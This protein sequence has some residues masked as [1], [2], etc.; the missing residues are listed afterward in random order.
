MNKTDIQNWLTEHEIPFSSSASLIQLRKL[1]N[2]KR[3]ELDLNDE[4][5]DDN[6][7]DAEN[8]PLNPQQ[9]EINLDAEIRILEK[10]QRIQQLQRELTI[11][12]VVSCPNFEDVQHLMN[13]F[14]ETYD[15]YKW[16]K[17]FERVCDS[18]SADDVFRLR[19]VRRLMKMNSA[20][21]LFLRVDNSTNFSNFRQNFLSNFGRKH[22]ISEV[23][24]ELRKTTYCSSKLSIIGYILKMQELA[25][26]ANMDE[27]EVIQFI[28][29]G[30]EDDSVDIAVLY[31]ANDL[32]QLKEL[33][34]RYG[35]LRS[36][37]NFKNQKRNPSSSF[38]LNKNDDI[39]KQ[40]CF[41]CSQIGHF[42]S[43]C[44]NPKREKGSCFRCG[45]KEHILNNC[46]K[47]S[48]PQVA[49]VDQFEKNNISFKTS[50]SHDEHFQEINDIR[51]YTKDIE[52]VQ[53]DL[54]SIQKENQTLQHELNL[55]K[56]QIFESE[57]TA[58]EATNNL[59]NQQKLLERIKQLEQKEIELQDETHELR[60]Q[61]ELLEFRILELEE[62]ND[63][64]S[65][66]SN[67]TPSSK[68][69]WNNVGG[70]ES[71][72]AIIFTDRS[73]S[74]VTSPHSHHH[75]DDRIN[76]ISPCDL[77]LLDHMTNEDLRR[78]LSQIL[79][80]PNIDEEDKICLQQVLAFVQNLEAMSH[81][82]DSLPSSEESSSLE[83]IKSR[84]SDYSSSS[85]SSD[86]SPTLQLQKPKSTPTSQGRIVATV[87]PYSSAVSTPNDSPQRK[88]RAW[89]TTSLTESG[90]FE[91]D[92][93]ETSVYPQTEP[94][95]FSNSTETTE[96]QK[97]NRIREQF[98]ECAKKSAYAK[99]PVT[100][101][102]SLS[103]NFSDQKRIQYY[104]E[105]LE[106]LEGKLLL[107]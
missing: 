5:N 76:V 45:S 92:L 89:H 50:N 70:K 48:N 101:S 31:P 64:W 26:Q 30:F 81:G 25:G 37:R 69:V 41:N 67:T 96:A 100:S 79:K 17:D 78:R 87:L 83:Y 11:N 73:D 60:E 47:K 94:E 104:K 10:R 9:E 105:R 18:L 61:N 95:D 44:P 63:K 29:A 91:G 103:P 39:K 80:K 7:N 106:V 40:K 8:E 85:R 6:F 1:Y 21:E 46:T 107:G 20:A 51:N 74:G 54:E 58:I 2:E 53:N 36:Q 84:V 19:S 13:P 15:G 99:V 34:H 52:K 98:E 32:Q 49:L 77:N 33:S 35:Q 65:L 57:K 28:I 62:S 93:S 14:D 75:I 43:S 42:S 88:L 68:N 38:S 4:D 56:E 22:T 3:N 23:I 27:K 24:N 59:K 12:S 71:D 90:V 16:L 86:I 102:Q 97:L 82:H 72:E 55:A 66:Q